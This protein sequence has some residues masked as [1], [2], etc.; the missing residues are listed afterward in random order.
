MMSINILK[1][2][3]VKWNINF[4]AAW[5]QKSDSAVSMFP[6]APGWEDEYL[7]LTPYCQESQQNTSSKVKDTKSFSCIA[8]DDELNTPEICKFL[9]FLYQI[10][11]EII[12]EM[13]KVY[14]N[15][16]IH[17]IHYIF[18]EFLLQPVLKDVFLPSSA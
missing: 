16:S 18:M 8:P 11:S 17:Y 4:L 1:N 12:N 6:M 13:K 3:N 14:V 10:H 7:D 2:V 9:T 5:S 15:P